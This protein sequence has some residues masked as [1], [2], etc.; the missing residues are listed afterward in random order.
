[1]ALWNRKR[2]VL[3]VGGRG[4]LAGGRN[5]LDSRSN[6]ARWAT[7]TVGRF[8]KWWI[9]RRLEVELSLGIR[10]MFAVLGVN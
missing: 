9:I 2:S 3:V 6:D 7:D 1:M 8:V 5:K 4:S 10:L